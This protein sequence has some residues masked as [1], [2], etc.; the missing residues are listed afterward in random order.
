MVA[1][2][3]GLLLGLFLSIFIGATFFVLI[4]T[5]IYR[6][7]RSALTM[8]LGVFIS[9]II[10]ILLTYFSTSG[11]L[12]S[13]ISNHYFKFAGSFAFL[14]F[15]L[16]YIFKKHHRKFTINDNIN[17]TRLFFNGMAINILNP[18]VI[19]FWIGSVVLVVSYKNFTIRQ[20]IIFY[21]SCLSVIMII[22]LVKIYF[23]S[24]L[25]KFID[26]KIL[27]TISVLAGVFFVFISLKILFQI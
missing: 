19:A 23:A 7:F 3:N 2:F 25:G 12:D 13:L 15:G 9:D 6:G 24:K 16:Y 22:D 1:M 21:S 20:T 4:E 17:Y 8:N 26:K 10:L 14:G 18:S 27:K 5:S 11:F